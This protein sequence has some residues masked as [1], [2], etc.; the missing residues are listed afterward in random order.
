M[1]LYRATYNLLK[2]DGWPLFLVFPSI[3]ARLNNAL[4]ECR[5]AGGQHE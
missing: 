1:K 2:R 5:S 4:I 3:L